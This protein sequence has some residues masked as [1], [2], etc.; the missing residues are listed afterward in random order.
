MLLSACGAE[1]PAAT[2]PTAAEPEACSGISEFEATLRDPG[3]SY[4]YEP[5]DSLEELAS[6]AD[7]IVVGTLSHADDAPDDL[8]GRG[9]GT[10]AFTIGVDRVLSQKAGPEIGETVTVVTDFNENARSIA[11]Y[12]EALPQGAM[13]VVFLSEWRDA[14]GFHL[15]GFWFACDED[16]SPG[17]GLVEPGWAV[18]SLGSMIEAIEGEPEIK[19][20]PSP[21][22]DEFDSETLA[23]GRIRI[24]P[25]SAEVADEGTYRFTVPHCGL[26]W[27][28]DF[29]ASFWKAEHPDG[30]RQWEPLSVLLQPR[31]GNLHLRHHGSC[32]LR[33]VDRRRRSTLHRLDGRIVITPCL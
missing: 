16:D 13:A 3:I 24:R 1:A 23:D 28:V 2:T 32:D 29:D 9:M 22:T 10:V 33:G 6:W 25:R 26:D 5:S 14:W 4:D 18:G 11:D 17:N 31:R 30:L 19:P 15:E 12:Q 21:T 27:M 7:A 8:A 20:E